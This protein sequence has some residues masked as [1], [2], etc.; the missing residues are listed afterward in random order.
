MTEEMGKRKRSNSIYDRRGLSLRDGGQFGSTVPFAEKSIFEN[1]YDRVIKVF[2]EVLTQDINQ[3]KTKKEVLRPQTSDV[4]NIGLT[5]QDTARTN[6]K[7]L[8]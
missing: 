1:I 7:N 8:N 2:S 5:S 4:R 3:S 6:E